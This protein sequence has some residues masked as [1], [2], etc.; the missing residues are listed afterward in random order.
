MSAAVARLHGVGGS[1]A[2]LGF[3]YGTGLTLGKIAPL[4]ASLN[5]QFG[6][7]LVVAGWLTSILALFAVL[8]AGRM[9]RLVPQIGTARSLKIAALA[10]GLGAVLCAVPMGM[11]GLIGARAIEAA[12]YALGAVAGPAYLSRAAQ[13]RSRPVF[14]ALWGSVVPVG[15]AVSAAITRILP[16][17]WPLDQML[18]ALAVPMLLL[19]FPVLLL[20]GPAPQPAPPRPARAGGAGRAAHQLAFGFGLYVCLSMGAFPFVPV[21]VVAHPALPAWLVLVALVVPLGSFC[22]AF[23]LGVLRARAAPW[24]AA[25]GFAL[26]M[27]GAAV[28]FSGAGLSPA[29]LVLY[30]FACGLSSAGVLAS[31][32]MVSDDAFSAAHAVALIS[33]YG[34]AAAFLGPPI[35]GFWVER[36]GWQALGEG[37]AVLA[38]GGAAMILWVRSPR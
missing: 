27:A 21:Y 29:A 23:L 38:L 20:D 26:A 5:A 28:M 35:A 36:F 30:S 32:L 12:G 24:I 9:G 15:F 22:A 14:M 13:E 31:V 3:G 18:A 19:A 16:Q 25:M 7:G 6:T 8:G 4:T 10:M 2:V 33:R 34:G 1:L 37:L 17:D 11:A